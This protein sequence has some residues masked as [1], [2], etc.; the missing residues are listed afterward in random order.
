MQLV[1]TERGSLIRRSKDR[2]RD[3]G[4]CSV[5]RAAKEPPWGRGASNIPEGGTHPSSVGV[6]AASQHFART[7]PR[8]RRLLVD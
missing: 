1:V 8:R 4:F 5:R 3:Y 7:W 2:G 6:T